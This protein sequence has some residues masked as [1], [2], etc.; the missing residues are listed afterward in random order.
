M[1]FYTF[2]EA[3]ISLPVD[4]NNNM[5]MIALCVNSLIDCLHG[6]MMI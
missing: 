2:R 5:N 1:V 3:R 6:V 4:F